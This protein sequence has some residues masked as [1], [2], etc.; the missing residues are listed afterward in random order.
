[1]LRKAIAAAA[2]DAVSG[3]LP[4]RLGADQRRAAA[5]LA[6]K[7]K[8]NASRYAHLPAKPDSRQVKRRAAMKAAKRA[9]RPRGNWRAALSAP[10]EA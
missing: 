6:A 1:M 2:F 7:L 8:A 4:P 5:R 3:L 10:T 9:S